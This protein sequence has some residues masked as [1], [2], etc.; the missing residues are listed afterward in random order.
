MGSKRKLQSRRS[1]PQVNKVLFNK[2]FIA[3]TLFLVW[4]LF[5]DEYN[6]FTQH[7]LKAKIELLESQKLEYAEKVKLARA[8]KMDIELNKEKY[9]REKYFMHKPNETVFI[10]ERNK[11]D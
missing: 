4:L 1:I 7:R 9:A 11:E 8:E 2:F 5:I 6:F 3:G 10:I